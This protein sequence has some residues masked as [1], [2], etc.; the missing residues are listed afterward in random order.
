MLTLRGA[1]P[2]PAPNQPG[3]IP[4]RSA[5]PGL[6]A[7]PGPHAVPA[8]P[9]RRS[10]VPFSL[11]SL[12]QAL[13][14][15]HGTAIPKKLGATL[16]HCHLK[17]WGSN[18]PRCHLTVAGSSPTAL[19][20][21][22][23]RSSPIAQPALHSLGCGPQ[24]VGYHR[25][26]CGGDSAS[27]PKAAPHQSIEECGNRKGMLSVFTGMG[28]GSRVVMQEAMAH[29]G[30]SP[31]DAAGTPPAAL[32]H[33]EVTPGPALIADTPTVHPPPGRG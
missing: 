1:R 29:P 22:K 2:C 10:P 28:L 30:C 24:A 15:A 25:P 23:R 21:Q 16:W 31:V 12:T 9:R 3:E 19:P 14:E 8:S 18:P 26:L 5:A 4:A 20:S 17:S 27:S 32:L 11:T 6:A 13:P 7:T 33:G